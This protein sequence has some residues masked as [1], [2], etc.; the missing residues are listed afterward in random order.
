MYQVSWEQ[1]GQKPISILSPAY[2]SNGNVF[3]SGCVGSKAD[4]SL[5]NSIE[6]QTELAI[7]NLDQILRNSN[8]SLN[9]VLKVL[10]FVADGADCSAV[11]EI[12]DKYFTHKP[13]RSCVLVGFPNKSIK[14][15]L[16]CI[17][18]EN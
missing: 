17:A 16:E 18:E 15:E 13:A 11:N 14:V 12:Y 8:S 10:L 1:V 2:K 4:G 5:G 3:T 7:V 9:K 6:E